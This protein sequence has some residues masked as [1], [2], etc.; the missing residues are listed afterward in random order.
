LY[1][2]SYLGVYKEVG[3]T[4]PQAEVQAEALKEV[5]DSQLITKQD[6][7]MLQ[8]DTMQINTDLTT[9]IELVRVDLTKEIRQVRTDL[10]KDIELVR[11][12]LTTKV[13]L[14][15]NDLAKEVNL[16]RTDLTKEIKQLE[17]RF[18]NKLSTE[19]QKLE[20]K[21]TIKMGFMFFIGMGALAAWMKLLIN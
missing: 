8:R 18:E 5:T 19:I 20:Y 13:D 1:L 14:V 15:R 4:E 2:Y 7:L 16:V 3:F 9:K 6:I 12:D 10:T 11:T 21:L 17:T